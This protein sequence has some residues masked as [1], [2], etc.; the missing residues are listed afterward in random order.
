MKDYGARVADEA[1]GLA[2]KARTA[3]ESAYD[4]GRRAFDTADAKL[5]ELS[6]FGRER[7]LLAMGIAFAAGYLVARI[8]ARR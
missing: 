5:D 4:A 1:A 6:H 3:A 7:P 2:D 8:F